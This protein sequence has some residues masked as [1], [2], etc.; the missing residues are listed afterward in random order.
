MAEGVNNPLWLFTKE[1][2]M[3]KKLLFGIIMCFI[4]FH[5]NAHEVRPGLLQIEQTGENTYKVLWKIPATGMAVPKIYLGLPDNW[6]Y[7]ARNASLIANSLR[8]EFECEVD[9]ANSWWQI[10]F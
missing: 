10:K 9:R 3:F 8:Q 6:S 7:K 1:S 4:A 2:K 5:A